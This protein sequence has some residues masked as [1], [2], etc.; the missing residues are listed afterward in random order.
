M[1]TLNQ[2]SGSPTARSK[3][4]RGVAAVEMALVLP[5]FLLVTMGMV[6][7]GRALMVGQLVTNAAREGARMAIL[8]GSSTASVKTSIQS[9]LAGA[10]GVSTGDITVTATVGGVSKDVSAAVAK[11]M[12]AIKVSIPFSKV[13]YLPPTYLKNT[14][15]TGD[16]SMRHE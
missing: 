16:S 1:R 14:T 15:L 12:I 3:E 11:E 13:S 6:E 9:F 2:H 10:A 5:I 4:R 8:D 7:F